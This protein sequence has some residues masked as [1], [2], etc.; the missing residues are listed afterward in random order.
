MFYGHLDYCQKSPLEGRPHSKPGGNLTL[1]TIEL[2][3]F[4]MVENPH[5]QKVIGLFG[6]GT[7]HI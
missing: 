7:G 4:I 5:E 2:L 1:A 3:Y 6:L